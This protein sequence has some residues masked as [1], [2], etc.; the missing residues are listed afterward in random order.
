M[1]LAIIFST[2]STLI[3]NQSVG[4]EKSQPFVFVIDSIL[5]I[6]SFWIALNSKYYWPIWFTG[7]HFITVSTYIAR[8][9]FPAEVP[10]LYTNAAGFWA[11]PALGSAAVGAIFDRRAGIDRTDKS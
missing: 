3:V 9:L 5:L 1:A 7:F 6:F 4:I 2:I 11:L 8:F 10:I